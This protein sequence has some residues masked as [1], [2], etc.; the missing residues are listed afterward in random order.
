MIQG[1]VTDG[2]EPQ[3]TFRIGRRE[4]TALVDTGFNGYL[5]LP[6]LL[7]GVLKPRYI[8]EVRSFLAGGRM[9]VE[10]NY[11][12]QFPFDG[13]IT[14]AE[15]SFAPGDTILVGTQLLRHHRLEINFP[16]QTLSLQRAA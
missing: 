5:E 16:E 15:V 12:V 2:Q 4:W 3:I 14:R 1:I 9:I 13:E 8:G 11:E 6:E 10:K 7:K